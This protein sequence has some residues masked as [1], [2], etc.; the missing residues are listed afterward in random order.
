MA[1]AC[2]YAS[3]RFVKAPP[4]PPGSHPAGGSPGCVEEGQLTYANIRRKGGAAEPTHG[5]EE[6]RPDTQ[7]HVVLPF[8]KKHNIQIL[9]MMCLILLAS[10][11]GIGSQFFQMYKNNQRQIS[12]LIQ[13]IEMMNST[14]QIEQQSCQEAH[15]ASNLSATQMIINC[16]SLLHISWEKQELS[17]RELQ[18]AT[19]KGKQMETKLNKMET[20]LEEVESPLNKARQLLD[21][22]EDTGT[23]TTS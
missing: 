2:N 6:K 8:W 12:N 11:I 21:D 22:Y 10:C 3:L 1:G 13:I 4:K 16:T 15:L 20:R 17:K 7:V 5:L 23:Y 14:M 19:E 18:N 9:L